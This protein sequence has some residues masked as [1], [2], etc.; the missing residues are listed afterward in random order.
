M[1]SI[2]MRAIK[3]A[4]HKRNQIISCMVS[5]RVL[6]MPFPEMLNFAFLKVTQQGKP[7]IILDEEI[8]GKPAK[9]FGVEG[10]FYRALLD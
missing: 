5:A 1:S 9:P 8:V 2:M 3:C 6:L 7:F 4:H 10:T